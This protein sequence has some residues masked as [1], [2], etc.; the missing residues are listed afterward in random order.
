MLLQY[1]PK[2]YQ[3]LQAR[4]LSISMMSQWVKNI[5]SALHA[6]TIKQKRQTILHEHK[7]DSEMLSAVYN[8][9]DCRTLEQELLKS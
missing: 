9:L 2:T 7:P 1:V 3:E 6:W 5:L 8:R 4:H